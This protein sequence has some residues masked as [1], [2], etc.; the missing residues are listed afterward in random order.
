M[1][2]EAA[3]NYTEVTIDPTW[4]DFQV[5]IDDMGKC[6]VGYS[7]DRKNNNSGYTKHNC[8]YIPK[9]DQNKNRRS[10]IMVDGVTLKEYSKLNNIP[11]GTLYH[12]VTKMNLSP[13]EAILWR[14]KKP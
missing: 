9:G 1:A 14:L 6:P 3:P 12:R 2:F 13:Q 11:Y 10:C 7:L 8:R 4:C 5:F